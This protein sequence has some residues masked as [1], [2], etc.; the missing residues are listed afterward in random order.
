MNNRN[1]KQ[2]KRK[3]YKEV[4][5]KETEKIRAERQR[6]R[7]YCIERDYVRWKGGRGNLN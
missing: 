6:T 4:K 7:R 3:L 5:E 1:E 2:E